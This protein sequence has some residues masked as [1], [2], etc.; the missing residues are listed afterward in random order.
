MTAFNGP[1]ARRSDKE[2]RL[3]LFVQSTQFGIQRAIEG[4][5]RGAHGATAARCS[6]TSRWTCSIPP[7]EPV[8]HE[9]AV[10]DPQI[11]RAISR[12]P[13]APG[14]KEKFGLLLKRP[15]RR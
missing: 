11:V 13:G 5:Y 6:S 3:A 10:R 15:R 4:V 1:K 2:G 8:D 9:A 14:G 7:D 12:A